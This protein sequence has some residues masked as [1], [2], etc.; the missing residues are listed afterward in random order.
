MNEEQKNG[1]I[2]MIDTTQSRSAVKKTDA[3]K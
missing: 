3:A 1:G 2:S